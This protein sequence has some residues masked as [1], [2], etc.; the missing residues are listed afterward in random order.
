M[1]AIELAEMVGKDQFWIREDGTCIH[2]TALVMGELGINVYIGPY[3]IIGYPSEYKDKETV[4]NVSI[5][6]NTK[7]HGHVTIDSGVINITTVAANCYLMKDVHIGHDAF[8]KHDVTISPGAKIGGHAVI[9]R[10]CNIGMNA[11]VH[12]HVTIPEGCMI[13]MGAIM[14]KKEYIPYSKY[15]MNGKYLDVNT[16]AIQ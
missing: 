7:I 8:I 3:C 9:G 14:V 2:K 10:K 13:G 12:Q 11:T 1:K 16:K 15:I 4:G 6:S 5:G